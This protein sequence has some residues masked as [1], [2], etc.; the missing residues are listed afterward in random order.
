MN[1]L[2]IFS[3]FALC[4]SLLL[5][6]TGGKIIAFGLFLAAAAYHLA[7]AF[8]FRKLRIRLHPSLFPLLLRPAS[9]WSSLKK[10]RPFP[11]FLGLSLIFLGAACAIPGLLLFLNVPSPL[12]FLSLF[13]A[14]GTL[15]VLENDPPFT[16]PLFLIQKDAGLWLINRWKRKEIPAAPEFQMERACFLSKEFP[17]LRLTLEHKGEKTAEIA[18]KKGEKPHLIF[19][20]LE[21]FRAKNVGCMGAQLPLSPR[22]DALAEKGLLFTRFH[23]A[24]NL[25]NR[26]AVA[27]L[28]GILPAYQAWHM[29]RYVGIPF[30]GLPQILSQFGY[31][32]ALIQGSSLA[33]D[34][35]IEFF[36]G[37]G[38]KTLLGKRDIE[39]QM[40][41]RG[42]SWGVFDEHLVDFSVSW[43]KEQKEPA[44]LTLFMITNHHPWTAPEE[45]ISEQE[46]PYLKTFSYTDWALGKFV[47]ELEK[48]GIL[49]NS[50]LFIF[51]DHGQELTDR[52][53]HFEINCHLYQENIH[54][55]LLIYGKNRI[56]NPKKIETLSSQV[57]LLPTV[58]DLLRIPGP[59][60]SMG[61]SLL[62]AHSKPIYFSYPF[63][64]PLRGCREED[65]KWLHSNGQDQLYDLKNDPEERLNC[66]AAHPEKTEHLKNLSSDH[67]ALVD[68]LYETRSFAPKT[69][70]SKTDSLHLDFSNSLRMTDELLIETARSCPR[71]A[72]LSLSRCVLITD[73]GIRGLLE[74][75]P[76]LEK[77]NLEGLDEITGED[78]PKAPHLMHFKAL[79]CPRLR[80]GPWFKSL[81]SLRIVQLGSDAMT[82]EDLLPLQKTGPLMTL[83]LSSAANITDQ[84]LAPLLASNPHLETLSLED[85]PQIG[86]AS[87][88]ALNGRLLSHLFISGCDRITD[89]AFFLFEA[90]PLRYLVLKN[91]SG[92]TPSGIAPLKNKPDLQ[93][94][95]LNC[96]QLPH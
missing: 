65:W 48:E 56:P 22:F 42:T 81:S 14:S 19:L 30:T 66:A 36:Q 40:R 87:L 45:W 96:P 73:L 77:L 80:P 74:L 71:L 94:L 86:N 8:L 34:H 31:H 15:S 63:D 23:A 79:E 25:T 59:H 88:A 53:P 60:H 62:R 52:D 85:C 27:S 46:H 28:Y 5:R 35:G 57:D 68:R 44:F 50:L 20:I 12:F 54:V 29:G 17:L 38:F 51:G 69:A 26:C 10:L 1:H 39:K 91:C 89:E 70:D 6:F 7:D 95:T 90:F 24:G 83:Q 11:L 61:S 18:L 43:L 64:P 92:I 55:P 72:S 58:L 13:F 41:C 76:H 33:F 78:W 4:A 2:F 3:Q 49:D 21:S 47:D 16:N 93:I 67:A 84:G 37:H 32:P 9:F 82:D 75:C